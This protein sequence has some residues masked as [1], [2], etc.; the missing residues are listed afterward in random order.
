M[1]HILN[2]VSDFWIFP[3][4]IGLFWRKKREVV[5]IRGLVIGPCAVLVTKYLTPVVRWFRVAVFVSLR[6]L[7][8]VPVPF[9]VVQ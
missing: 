6:L 3:I 2:R 5:L 8:D 1:H 7:P 4:Q 9:R